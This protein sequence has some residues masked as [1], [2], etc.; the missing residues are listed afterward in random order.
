MKWIKNKINNIPNKKGA[1]LITLFLALFIAIN[2]YFILT[3]NRLHG[4]ENFIR[5]SVITISII[6][7]IIM[8]L[9]YFN[10][11]KKHYIRRYVIY[12]LI[13]IIISTLQSFVGYN[14]NK[15]LNAL[16]NLNKEFITYS[17]SLI[18]LK[19]INI[20]TINQ[21]NNLKIGIINDKNNIEGYVIGKEIID[22]YNLKKNNEIIN[23]DNFI[24]MILSLY[25]EKID[26]IFLSSNYS[27]MFSSIDEFKNIG[28]DT[29]IIYAQDKKME[30]KNAMASKN[31][32]LT[33][34][35]TLLIMGVDSD[36]EGLDSNAAFNGDTLMLITFN[37]NTLNAT[38][39]SIPRDTYV[40]IMCF[41][42]QIENKI[43]HSGWYGKSC[44]INTIENFTGIN[45]DYYVTTN[46]R[47]VIDLVDTLGG[48]EI[49]VP[50]N[51]CAPNSKRKIK[52]DICVKKG[53]QVLNGEQTLAFMRNR[54]LSRGDIDRGRNQQI[55]VSAML[56][57]LKDIR[58][59]NQVHNILDTISNNIDT[60][61]DTNEILSFYDVGKDMISKA[62]NNKGEL[63]SMQRLH[64]DG[65][66]AY[67]WDEGMR[68]TLYNYIYT[69][70]SLKDIV[71]AMEIN[72]G[73]REPK[74]IKTFSFSINEKY[75]PKTIGEGPY[76]R[77]Y[78]IPTVPDFT[79][80]TKEG[81]LKWGKTNNIKMEFEI[82]DEKHPNYK[83]KY[84]NGEIIKQSIP[85]GYK[86]EKLKNG[87][88]ITLQ[89]VSK[90][91]KKEP[92][93]INCSL[94]ENYDKNEC[95]LPD[96]VGWTYSK[97]KN[98]VS[99]LSNIS[100][101]IDEKAITITDPLD[102]TKAGTIHSQSVEP[103]TPLNEVNVLI[104]EYYKELNE[105][106]IENEDN[107]EKE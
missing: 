103:G 60:N 47:G 102:T 74:L 29:K 99:A 71:K 107:I 59:L 96:M 5:Y 11:I 78:F 41:K 56:N 106:N 63:I 19:D 48:V 49:N 70:A 73:I 76:K 9:A 13:I 77:D 40:P 28:E 72:L 44:I 3:L 87:S 21:V 101:M 62:S 81:A 31:K 98:W 68:M 7:V 67:I 53:L 82:V 105:E 94:E 36:R 55:V 27:I 45:I 1:F 91:E 34:P 14:I 22:E 104:I 30:K 25:E 58:S 24:D 39:W 69:K 97:Y 43:T 75:T 90:P 26:L 89:I 93:K 17:T 50:A 37:P 61:L 42:G 92:T 66:G 80:Y 57:K 16:D 18:G 35:F 12:I 79:R 46:F 4:I 100:I 15:G 51:F 2:I 23:Y 8:L 20:D 83:E 38:I 10:V 85:H 52:K 33:E 6:L 64:L 86:M 88:T 32:K 54:N 84:E 95:L 65:Y